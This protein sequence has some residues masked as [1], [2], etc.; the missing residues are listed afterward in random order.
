MLFIRLKAE[1]MRLCAHNKVS[2]ASLYALTVRLKRCTMVP[3]LI[4][5]R[6]IHNPM[7]EHESRISLLAFTRYALLAFILNAVYSVVAFKLHAIYTVG[8]ELV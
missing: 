4:I 1:R 2:C 6:R 3:F 7:M 5:M 8:Y